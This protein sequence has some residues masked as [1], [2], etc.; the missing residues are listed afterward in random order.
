MNR[1]TFVSFLLAACSRWFWRLTP[2]AKQP[3]KIQNW[4]PR[5]AREVHELFVQEDR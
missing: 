3:E 1:R 4:P 5:T 2:Q